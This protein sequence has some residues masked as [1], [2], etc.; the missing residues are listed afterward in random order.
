MQ[1]EIAYQSLTENVEIRLIQDITY[2]MA[3][4]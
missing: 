1:S 4:L 2:N 3:S